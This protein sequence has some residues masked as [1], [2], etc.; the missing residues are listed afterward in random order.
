MQVK[1]HHWYQQHQRQILPPVP[2]VLLIRQIDTGIND[3]DGEFVT[4]VNDNGGKQWEQYQT[5]ENLK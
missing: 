1:V 4:G 2:L 3:T 5:A